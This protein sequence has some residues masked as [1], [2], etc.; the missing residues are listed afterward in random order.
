MEC[1]SRVSS[2][3]NIIDLGG[4]YKYW[5]RVGFDFLESANINIT[6]VNHI[7]S[8]LSESDPENE[9]ITF[10]VSDACNLNLYKDNSFDFVHSNSVIEHVGRWSEMRA[11]AKE[12]H[13]LAPAYYIQTPYFWF[14]IDPHFHNVP[15]FHW[16][17][18][19]LRL[20]ILRRMRVGWSPPIP[21]LDDAMA[22]VE[23][24]V[25]LDA[26]QFRSLFPD[27]KIS[28]ERFA[29]FPKSMVAIRI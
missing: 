7:K 10:V 4:T 1:R 12:A 22:A 29:L 20:K 27:A 21:A 13:R 11:F 17:P 16:M 25:I 18:E 26:R 15:F 5:E 3:F 19:S 9:R 2:K 14:P 6:C 8:E 28:F 23:S 24:A